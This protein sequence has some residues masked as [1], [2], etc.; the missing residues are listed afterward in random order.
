MGPNGCGSFKEDIL[1]FK[2][3]TEKVFVLRSDIVMFATRD[4]KVKIYT[5]AATF[6]V[7]NTL[8][9][10]EVKLADACFFRSHQS[11]LINLNKVMKIITKET[12]RYVVFYGIKRTAVISKANEQKLEAMIQSI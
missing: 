3:G 7:K 5:P 8:N 10:I 12:R 1:C 4:R 11:Y 2:T 9:E 6:L